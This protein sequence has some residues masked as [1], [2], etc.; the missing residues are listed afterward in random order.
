MPSA[1]N[2][3]LGRPGFRKF[4]EVGTRAGLK[5]P[6]EMRGARKTEIGSDFLG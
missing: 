4:E 1:L 6:A 3:W 5:I 2:N